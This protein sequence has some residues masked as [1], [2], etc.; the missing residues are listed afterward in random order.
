MR[1]ADKKRIQKKV[2]VIAEENVII[3]NMIMLMIL[4][5]FSTDDLAVIIVAPNIN[6]VNKM[7]KNCNLMFKTKG[8]GGE[9]TAF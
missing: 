4:G 8:G 2:R 7:V 9:A 3:S 5:G 1:I 6:S